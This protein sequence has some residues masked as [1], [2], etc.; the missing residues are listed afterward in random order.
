M[1]Y[2]IQT[3][4]QVGVITSNFKQIKEEIL[5]EIK[6]YQGL[7]F[8]EDQVAKAKEVKAKLNKLSKALNDERKNQEKIYNAPFEVFKKDVRELT[9]IIDKASQDIDDQVKAF[10]EKGRAEKKIELEQAYEDL[11]SAIPF[12][13]IFNDKWLNKTVTSK[14]AIEEMKET[15]NKID[16]DLQVLDTFINEP[17]T[18]ENLK[19]KYLQCHDISKVIDDYKRELAYKE[20]L[21]RLEEERKAKAQEV[22]KEEP[23]YKLQF[24]FEGTKEE[25]MNLSSF[26]KANN[27]KYRR[28]LGQ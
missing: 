3:N 20:Q 7:Q 11:K 10:D 8:T 9:D 25:I 22:K 16:S 18:L 24:E 27:Y 4:V 26:L 21:K 2:D 17:Q 23:I 14:K 19:L 28:L 15:L 6:N 5:V 1:T 12:D 13:S